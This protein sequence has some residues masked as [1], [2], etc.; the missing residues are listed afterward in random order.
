MLISHAGSSM[1]FTEFTK[2]ESKDMDARVLNGQSLCPV[3]DLWLILTL[4]T[5]AKIFPQPSQV[6]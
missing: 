1:S 4:L 3:T 5:I 2:V 6:F